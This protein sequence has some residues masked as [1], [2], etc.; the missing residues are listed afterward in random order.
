MPTTYNSKVVLSNGTV[1]M[2]ISEDTV[3][4]NKLLYGYTAHK[5][6]GE[7]ITG[8]C[9][10]DATTASD[11]ALAS[12]ILSGKTAHARGTALEGTMAN[13]GAVTG[14]IT[15]ASTPYTIQ[16]GYH[17]GTGT[18]SISS[19]TLLEGNI[20]SGVTILGVTGNYTGEAISAETRNITPTL[21]AQV[22]T[23]SSGYDYIAQV[24][25]AAI[26]IDYT[27]NASGGNTVTIG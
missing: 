15:S 2:D 25:L 17:D 22:I 27:V 4:A 16:Q 24:N 19:Q 8:S 1:I 20:K 18:V 7:P 6:N 14:T 11:T 23:P 10:F 5:A 9:T 21:T 3:V 13:R 12:E 26:P